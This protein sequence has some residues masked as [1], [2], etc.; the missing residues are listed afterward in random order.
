MG[1]QLGTVAL[2]GLA[3]RGAIALGFAFLCTLA[4]AQE[5]QVPPLSGRVVDAAGVLDAT[6][7][8]ALES[9]LEAFELRKGTQIVV[10]IVD[11]TVPEPIE[12]FG[13]RVAESW[14]VGRKGVDDGLLIIVASG[15][16][17]MRIEVGYGLEGVIPDATAKRL[18]EEVFI[19]GFQG[20]DFNQGLSAGVDRVMALIDG[21]PLPPPKP[22]GGVGGLQSLQ[23][24]FVVFMMLVFVVGGALRAMLGRLP[25]ASLV[26][27]GTGVLA[28]LVAAP[29]LAAGLV[30]LVAFV[31]TL[32]GGAAAGLGGRRGRGGFGS[33]GFGGGGFGGGGLG[34]GFGGGGGGFGG[35][36]ASGRW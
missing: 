14:K 5:L 29:L 21:E 23:G 15:D 1:G 6:Q 17:V 35:G 32:F 24:Y 16:R 25:A 13:I 31:F 8:Q 3:A 34:G 7:Q 28:W 18:I 27:V 11:S 4:V 12:A 2:C 10:L 36:G 33:G 19:P 22:Q 30:A 26:G 9:K 20:G